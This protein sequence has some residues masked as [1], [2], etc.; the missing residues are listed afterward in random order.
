MERSRQ[1]TLYSGVVSPDTKEARALT[2]NTHTLTTTTRALTILTGLH[3]DAHLNLSKLGY[4]YTRG[5]PSK[6]CLAEKQNCSRCTDSIMSVETW[7]YHA[8]L[9]SA[10]ERQKSLYH[11]VCKAEGP[12]TILAGV[13][14]APNT[15]Q[16][17]PP[18]STITWMYGDIHM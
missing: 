18:G 11:L 6:K 12:W 8:A 4:A 14:N 17:K 15:S 5:A 9:F 7:C 10:R 16:V 13:G 3:A 2:T 1:N